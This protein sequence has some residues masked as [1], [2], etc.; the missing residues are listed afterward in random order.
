MNNRTYLSCF[1]TIA[2]LLLLAGCTTIQSMKNSRLGA[3]IVPP[4]EDRLPEGLL[5]V[6]KR[7]WVTHDG[8]GGR[9]VEKTHRENYFGESQLVFTASRKPYA[10]G[11]ARQQVANR[12]NWRRLTS[13][14]LNLTNT[15]MHLFGGGV[16]LAPLWTVMWDFDKH[17]IGK[18]DEGKMMRMPS[19]TLYVAYPELSDRPRDEALV[20]ATDDL[21]ERLVSTGVCRYHVTNR[22]GAY[23][24]F[25]PDLLHTRRLMCGEPSPEV[26]SAAEFGNAQI[27]TVAL[28]EKNPLSRLFGVGT[29]VSTFY[30]VPEWTNYGWEIQQKFHDYGWMGP[31]FTSALEGFRALKPA[32]PARAYAVITGPDGEGEWK[33]FVAQGDTMVS[34]EP[35]W[36]RAFRRAQIQAK[37]ARKN[38]DL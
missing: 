26:P 2:A 4:A 8:W 3:T 18:S 6:E 20:A 24:I 23:G 34:Y 25:I 11:F 22:Q 19:L 14:A 30:W 17:V 37:Q 15:G 7:N 9:Q 33:V 5:A 31:Q 12:V 32:I 13:S 36:T 35:P 27:N 1:L 38:L 21:G 28:S 10:L 29:I 16:T